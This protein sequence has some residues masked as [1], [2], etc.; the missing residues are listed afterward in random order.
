VAK[1]TYGVL[2]A[3]V[4]Y[5]VVAGCGGVLGVEEIDYDALAPNDAG[6]PGAEAATVGCSVPSDCAPLDDAPAGCS[7]ASC[8][9]GKCVYRARDADGDGDRAAICTARIALETGGDCDDHDPTISS[10]KRRDCA[11]FPDGGTVSFPGG[12]PQGEC[13]LGTQG[14]EGKLVGACQGVVAPAKEVCD[15]VKDENCDGAVDDGCPCSGSASRPCGIQVGACKGGMQTCSAGAWGAC[16]GGAAP[17]PIACDGLDHDC[18]GTV[19]TSQLAAV[20][21]AD[22]G[23]ACV[24]LYACAAADRSEICFRSGIGYTYYCTGTRRTLGYAPRF[25]ASGTP[26]GTPPPGYVIIA[27]NANNT[28][29]GPYKTSNPCCGSAGC[30]KPGDTYDGEY[31]SVGEA[32]TQL[33][34]K[35]P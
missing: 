8:E 3:L 10:T 21:P 31:I 34:T 22:V 6:Q 15:G 24:H 19:D 35:W 28:R 13:K 32:M 27:N 29:V 7:E 26:H 5:L 14:C 20:D 11:S 33:Y 23:S 4:G 30:S 25:S 12:H 1:A 17:G 2:T 18:D 9:G 16:L